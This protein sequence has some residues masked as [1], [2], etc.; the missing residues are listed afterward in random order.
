MALKLHCDNCD[1][2]I[3]SYWRYTASG[4]G[5]VRELCSVKCVEEKTASEEEA[6]LRL[7]LAHMSP[8]DAEIRELHSAAIKEATAVGH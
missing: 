1:A 4:L 5:V 2:V 7:N 6:A 8:T 3:D